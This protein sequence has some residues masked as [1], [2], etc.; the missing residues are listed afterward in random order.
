[1]KE[2]IQQLISD[3]D[4]VENIAWKRRHFCNNE[5][6]INEG[7]EGVAI[8]FVEQGKLLVNVQVNL[9]NQRNIQQGVSELNV[10][11]IFGEMCL[12]GAIIRTASVKAISEGVLLEINAIELKLYLDR[13]P[14][15]GYSMYKKMFDLLVQRLSRANDRIESLF[16]WG[17]KAHG[18]ESHL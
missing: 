11:D 9:D 17:L 7:D 13:H 8:Y 1:L 5:L 12:Q 16:A 4:F 15:L 14:A 2:L 10:G 18:I 3:Q 6:I